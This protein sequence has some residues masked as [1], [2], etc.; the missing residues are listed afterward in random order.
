MKTNLIKI[1]LKIIMILAIMFILL[2]S[3]AC[4][5]PRMFDEAFGPQDIVADLDLDLD[6]KEI[7]SIEVSGQRMEEKYDISL[8][9]ISNIA[10]ELDDPFEPFYIIEEQTEEE[11]VLK[12]ENIF[13]KEGDE[14]A[15]ITLNEF[16]Y[17]LIEGDVFDVI[18]QVQ[19]INQDSVALLKG[20][21]IITLFIDEIKY[22]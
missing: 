17:L 10:D 7:A 6:E 2:V 19:S 11:N 9:D 3:S 1:F 14:Y 15:E 5:I 12:L 16:Q 22:D 20:D 18:Y 8:E 21:E 4:A 13:S